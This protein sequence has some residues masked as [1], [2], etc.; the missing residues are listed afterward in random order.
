MGMRGHISG[1]GVKHPDHADL[2]AEVFRVQG[3]SLQGG[4]G[5]LKEQVVHAVL[6][7]AGHRPSC[8]GQGKSE[9]KIGHGQEEVTL[10]VQ[11]PVV[12]SAF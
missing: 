3:E 4:S 6:V 2:P 7:R 10:L 5:G 12:A 8:L 1:P 11:P 9:Q